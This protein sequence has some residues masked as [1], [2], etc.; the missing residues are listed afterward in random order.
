MGI[1]SFDFDE[2]ATLA[3]SA[4][5]VFELRRSEYIEHL[6]SEC[7]GNYSVRDLQ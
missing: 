3:K 4:P 1:D 2:W 6:I 7:H 5:D